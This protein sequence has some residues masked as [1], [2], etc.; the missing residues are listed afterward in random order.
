MQKANAVLNGVWIAVSNRVGVEDGIPY[1]GSS[2]FVDP[3][4]KIKAMANDKTDEVLVH[5]IDFEQI[6]LARQA[7]PLL[8]D[9]RPDTYEILTKSFGSEAYY[10]KDRVRR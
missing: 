2:F 3:W 7:Y 6:R 1:L 4:G 10:H 5:E 9:R 8:R